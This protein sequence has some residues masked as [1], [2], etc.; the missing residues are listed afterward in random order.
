MD[1]EGNPVGSAL[2]L[3]RNTGPVQLLEV[4]IKLLN[5]EEKFPYSFY[6]SDQELLVQLGT[7]LEKSKVSVEKVLQIVYQPQAIFRIRPVNRCS[8]TI[9]DHTE[10]LL[11]VAFSPDGVSSYK[12]WITGVSCEP[13][14]LQ[15]PCHQFVSSNKDGD[16]RIQDVSLTKCVICLSGHTLALTCVKWSGDRI[17][18]TNSQDCTIKVWETTEGKLVRELKTAGCFC[19][20]YHSLFALSRGKGAGHFT[21]Q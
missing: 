7:Y 14:H 19:I 10:A 21:W 11:S 6:I 18:Y 1:P 5:N 2:Y 13:A 8:A 12:K 9:A 15:S 16:A 20:P 4:V 17:I 3:P